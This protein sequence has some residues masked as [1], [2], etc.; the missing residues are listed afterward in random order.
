MF[1][2]KLKNLKNNN[3]LVETNTNSINNNNNNTNSSTNSSTRFKINNINTIFSPNDVNFIKDQVSKNKCQILMLTKNDWSNTCFRY[4]KCFELQNI[5]CIL[6]KLNHHIFN[7]PE[8]GI[9][10]NVEYNQ[11]SEYPVII[12]INDEYFI[13]MIRLIA[14]KVKYIWCHASTIFMF[15]NI[16]IFNYFRNKEFIVAH[17]GTTYREN[18][19]KVGNIFNKFVSKTLIQCPDLLDLNTGNKNEELIYYPVDL[20]VFNCN[21]SF[22]HNQKLV[23]GHNPSTSTIKGTQTILNVLNLFQNQIIYHGQQKQYKQHSEERERVS[24]I[25]QIKKYQK[26]DVYIETLNPTINGKPYGE[27]GNTCLEAIASGCLVIT[28]CIHLDKYI[29]Y[30]KNTPPLLIANTKDELIEQ[31]KKLLSMSRS[32]ILEEKKKQYEWIKNYHSM[33]KCGERLVKFLKK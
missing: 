19:Q 23:F 30:Y 9:V 24:W 33:N 27:W 13:N 17:G 1:N 21:F 32:E 12:N 4:K 20:N 3:N 31:I 16:P 7:Y 29:K 28:N 25:N 5:N 6:I 18:P 15:K 2:M 11:T 14:S 8:Q 22:K 10:S 26:Y